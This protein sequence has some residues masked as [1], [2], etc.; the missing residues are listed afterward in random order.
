[1]QERERTRKVQTT[2]RLPKPL[3]EQARACVEKGYSAAESMNDFI[4]A[5]IEAYMRILRRKRIDAAFAHVAED[6]DYQKQGQLIAE[7]FAQSD[8]EALDIAEELLRKEIDA[9]R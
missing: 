8:W 1:M 7:E 5:A 6:A 9:P 4:I 2:V 3:Y